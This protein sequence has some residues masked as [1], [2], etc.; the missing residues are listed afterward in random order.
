M[1]KPGI[2]VKK[3]GTYQ[4]K[5]D[6]L[7]EE[8][9]ETQALQIDKILAWDKLEVPEEPL[10]EVDQSNLSF[11]KKLYSW[12]MIGTIA[13]ILTDLGKDLFNSVRDLVKGKRRKTSAVL[14]G[15]IL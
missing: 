12:L 8:T 1:S 4:R 5:H 3:L 7:S 9:D 15:S 11:R 6:L 13:N 14:T 10:E 2:T